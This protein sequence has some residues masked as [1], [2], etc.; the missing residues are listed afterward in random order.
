MNQDYSYTNA[1]HSGKSIHILTDA[2]LMPYIWDKT[3]AHL[4]FD[5]SGFPNEPIHHRV[6]LRY[7]AVSHT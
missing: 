4:A 6:D 2:E 5:N 1:L 3:A 7:S